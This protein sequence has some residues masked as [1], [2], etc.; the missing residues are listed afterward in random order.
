MG[1]T[2]KILLFT[3]LLVVALVGGT[4]AYTTVEAER[5]ARQSIATTA[6]GRGR[7]TITRWNGW[8]PKSRR[9]TTAGSFFMNCGSAWPAAPAPARSGRIWPGVTA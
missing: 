3:S 1:L 2:Q 4:V 8:M 5:M 6:T 7:S 9:G